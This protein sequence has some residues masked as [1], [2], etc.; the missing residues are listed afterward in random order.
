MPVDGDDANAV[1]DRHLLIVDN[2]TSSHLVVIETNDGNLEL[3]ETTTTADVDLQHQLAS[4]QEPTTSSSLRTSYRRRFMSIKMPF[5]AGRKRVMLLRSRL[6]TS[7]IYRRVGRFVRRGAKQR[8]SSHPMADDSNVMI[9]E[10]DKPIETRQWLKPAPQL[11]S[12]QS[13]DSHQSDYQTPPDN[14]ST[15][16]PSSTIERIDHHHG[17]NHVYDPYCPIHGSRRRIAPTIKPHQH[18]YTHRIGY[19]SV[20][21]LD[22]DGLTSPTL[23]SS[24]TFAAKLIRKR[25]RAIATGIDK[26][27]IEKEK[28]K[29]RSNLLIISIAFLFLFTAV[30]GLQNLQT[31]VNGHMGALSLSAVYTSLALSSLGIPTFMID[32]LGCKLTIVI[33]M[34]VHALYMLANFIPQYYSLMPASVLAGIASACLWSAKCAYITKSGIRYA[35]LNIEAPVRHRTLLCIFFMIVHMGQVFG[36]LISSSIIA[37]L[38]S[39]LIERYQ[40]MPKSI[41]HVDMHSV[42]VKCHR[43]PSTTLHDPNS[44]YFSPYAVCMCVVHSL[45]Q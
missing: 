36:N 22:F 20:D 34:I 18:H 30:H 16:L 2:Q 45:Q 40:L 25:K 35:Q 10:S 6:P 27:R 3:L 23:L 8:Q 13:I 42:V 7:A 1:D 33:S 31:S 26:I 9:D 38:Q 19:A 37:M 12:I 39:P 29:I 41:R 43:A 21:T 44:V 5:T 32:R 28:W 11:V 4:M 15:I 14:L 24:H 17:F